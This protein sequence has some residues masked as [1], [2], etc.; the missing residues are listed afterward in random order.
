MILFLATK[1]YFPR[2]NLELPLSINKG[3][4]SFAKKEIKLADAIMEKIE[5]LRTY[6]RDELV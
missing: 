3:L 5:V 1:D 6:L 2:L 4:G